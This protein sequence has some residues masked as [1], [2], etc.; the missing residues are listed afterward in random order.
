MQAGQALVRLGRE[1]EART[2]FERGIAAA[3]QKQELHARDEMQAMLA[4]LD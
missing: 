2:I 4:D 1:A 3:Q